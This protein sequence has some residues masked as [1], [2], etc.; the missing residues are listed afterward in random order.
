MSHQTAEIVREVMALIRRAGAGE[1]EPRLWELFAPE[2]KLD[3]SRRTFNP[4][5]YEGH[6]GLRRFR[7]EMDEVWEEFV[8]TPEQMIDAGE[9]VVVFEA[10]SARGRGSG[11]ETRSR[12]TSVWTVRDGQVIDMAVYYD[13]REA[14][15]E[16][17][18]SD[19]R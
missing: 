11:V 16:A 6:A 7:R 10:L 18:L 14:L 8:V 1:P 13:P 15:R 9:K 4:E 17:G 12:S 19:S 5:V 3:M 2:M